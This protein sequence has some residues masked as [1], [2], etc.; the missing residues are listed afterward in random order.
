MSTGYN[1]SRNELTKWEEEQKKKK[2]NIKFDHC[3][4]NQQDKRKCPCPEKCEKRQSDKEKREETNS[5]IKPIHI[6]EYDT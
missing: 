2:L 1:L 4:G 6:L 3:A 5:F